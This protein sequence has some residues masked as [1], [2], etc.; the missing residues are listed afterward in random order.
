MIDSNKD[1]LSLVIN[2]SVGI[3]TLAVMIL[4]IVSY[5]TNS[6][7]SDP[8][9]NM[10]ILNSKPIIQS[11]GA[12]LSSNNPGINFLFGGTSSGCYC[13]D[14][15]NMNNY[16]INSNSCTDEGNRKWPICNDVSSL[17]GSS[18]NLWKGTRIVEFE[19]LNMTYKQLRLNSDPS[20]YCNP[21]FK[22]CGVLDSLGNILCINKRDDCP[23]NKISFK[24]KTEIIDPSE[25]Q[26][27]LGGDYI[28]TYS[29]SSDLQVIADLSF[30]EGPQKVICANSQSYLTPLA[31]SR[32]N[33]WRSPNT[34]VTSCK[35]LNGNNAIIYNHNYKL[36]DS[37]DA[38]KLYSANKILSRLNNLPM[39][40]LNS[41]MT[42]I[43]MFSRSYIGYQLDCKR[44]YDSF[45]R[46]LGES[47]SSN[48]NTLVKLVVFGILSFVCS[49]GLFVKF[50]FDNRGV[51]IFEMVMTTVITIL[52]LVLIFYTINFK[53]N[54]IKS[55]FIL[56]TD[57]ITSETINQANS[58]FIVTERIVFSSL[59]LTAV[60]LL[61][62][63]AN[64][65]IQ[66]ACTNHYNHYENGQ[67][68][69]VINY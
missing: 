28:L 21:D 55:D 37:I 51:F 62:L 17:K 8:L 31:Y 23:V 39:F 67:D 1:L 38:D 61:L 60:C 40:D 44:D 33:L 54:H 47:S 50:K 46:A 25:F 10:L 3:L 57:D 30:S 9:D 22:K 53:K 18:L 69:L 68:N 5:Y 16:T 43:N 11:V 24:D 26:V 36:I 49:A 41:I 32:Y 35:A 59:V 27:D 12:L 56:C 14:Y 45:E 15:F 58:Y 42:E 34:E 52:I 19:Y 64:Y 7:G 20:G 4:T 13:Y 48:K 63:V 65:F 29:N 2:I 6:W 66:L